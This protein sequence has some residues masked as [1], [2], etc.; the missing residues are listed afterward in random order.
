MMRSFFKIIVVSVLL[1]VA[2]GV[3][4][5]ERSKNLEQPGTVAPFANNPNIYLVAQA[6]RV[7][8]NQ[9]SELNGDLVVQY[10]KSFEDRDLGLYLVRNWEDVGEVLFNYCGKPCVKE[11]HLTLSRKVT[12]INFMK[13]KK[14][15]FLNLS[16]FTTFDTD[17]NMLSFSPKELDCLKKV[18][19]REIRYLIP[20]GGSVLKCQNDLTIAKGEGIITIHNT[21]S[22]SSN[23]QW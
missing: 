18:L 6:H 22:F 14:D 7:I 15:L 23:L 13:V 11:G 12:L 5:F 21:S 2:I 19:E 20:E 16:D 10:H 8:K 3:L 4:A 9:I 1:V 17:T